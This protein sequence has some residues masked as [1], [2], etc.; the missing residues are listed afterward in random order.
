MQ[1]NPELKQKL[2]ADIQNMLQQLGSIQT[3]S[4]VVAQFSK[5]QSLYEKASFLKMEAEWSTVNHNPS[6]QSMA[7]SLAALTPGFS[8][9]TLQLETAILPSST[10][11]LPVEIQVETPAEIT[12]S[13]PIEIVSEYQNAETSPNALSAKLADFEEAFLPSTPTEPESVGLTS[14]IENHLSWL[15]PESINPTSTVANEAVSEINPSLET[16]IVAPPEIITH[17]ALDLPFAPPR[18]TVVSEIAQNVSRETFTA[19]NASNTASIMPSSQPEIEPEIS[20]ETS[21]SAPSSQPSTEL[22]AQE[23]KSTVES[24]FKLSHIKGM[25]SKPE[26]MA[27]TSIKIEAIPS[28]ETKTPSITPSP[29]SYLFPQKIVLDL[30]DKMAFEQHLFAHDP[31]LLK[32]CID[33]LNQFQSEEGSKQYLTGF[34]T[35][36]SINLQNEYAQRLFQLIENKFKA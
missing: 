34:L 12:P 15:K 1:L 25:S 6:N 23:P 33:E 10:Q 18:E 36:N 32:A 16:P 28:S 27:E 20:H 13:E 19:L 5:F 8:S 14:P 30:N 29:K 22:L 3:P 24:K 26:A 2:F 7:P 9:E 11:N 21:V 17:A 35:Q 31:S 4:G